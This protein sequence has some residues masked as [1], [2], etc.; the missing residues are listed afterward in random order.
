MTVAVAAPVV[1][2]PFLRAVR[3]RRIPHWHRGNI[4]TLP[5]GIGGRIGNDVI[6][7][8]IRTRDWIERSG[9]MGCVR[10]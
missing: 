8:R 3:T 5:F 2:H 9:K 4:V 7:L 10:P 1:I 6:S